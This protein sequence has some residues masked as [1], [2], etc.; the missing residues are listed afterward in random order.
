MLETISVYFLKHQGLE[1][2]IP[3]TKNLLQTEY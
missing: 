2:N 3:K 1:Q